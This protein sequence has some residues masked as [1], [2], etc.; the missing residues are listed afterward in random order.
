MVFG[1]ASGLKCDWES[2][3]AVLISDEPLPTELQGLTWQWETELDTSKILGF[4]IGQDISQE[5]MENQLKGI[6]TVRIQKLK[7]PSN[8]SNG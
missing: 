1:L 5:L 2:T 3:S 8:Q 7:K 6:L 4:Y